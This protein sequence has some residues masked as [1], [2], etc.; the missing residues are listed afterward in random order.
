MAAHWALAVLRKG[1]VGSSCS[2]RSST[3]LSL[4]GYKV[5]D[6]LTISRRR[7]VGEGGGWPASQ[8]SSHRQCRLPGSWPWRPWWTRWPWWPWWWRWVSCF[9]IFHWHEMSATWLPP[10]LLTIQPITIA[11]SPHLRHVAE[12]IQANFLKEKASKHPRCI[13]F[14]TIWVAYC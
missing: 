13:G 12:S 14:S 3:H 11:S 2:G 8:Y 6:N 7:G 10:Y 9:T 5:H 4:D 1:G